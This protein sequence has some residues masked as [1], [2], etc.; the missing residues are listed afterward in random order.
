MKIDEL[1][2]ELNEKEKEADLTYE[3]IK[4]DVSEGRSLLIDEKDFIA[5]SNVLKS[6]KIEG[7]ISALKKGIS[8]CEEILNQSQQLKSKVSGNSSLSEEVQ[9]KGIVGEF[10]NSVKETSVETAGNPLGFSSWS[11]DIQTLIKQ[12]LSQRNIEKQEVFQKL[13]SH[14]PSHK[15]ILEIIRNTYNEVITEFTDS[16]RCCEFKDELIKQ[17]TTTSEGKE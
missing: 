16:K 7:E 15:E 9:T 12:S 4:K 13:G 3:L 8:A 6:H 11:A 1:K 17:L 14:E 10:N 2:A 5:Y